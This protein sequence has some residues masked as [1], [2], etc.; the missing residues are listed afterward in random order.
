MKA[1]PPHI[2][3]ERLRQLLQQ[4][5]SFRITN[6]ADWPPEAQKFLKMCA[7]YERFP[8][9][10]RA[11]AMQCIY[12]PVIVHHTQGQVW[13]YAVKHADEGETNILRALLLSPEVEMT[14]DGRALLNDFVSRYRIERTDNKHAL[15]NKIV[16]RYRIEGCVDGQWDMRARARLALSVWKKG[17]GRPATPIYARSDRDAQIYC[18]LHE[19]RTLRKIF[20]RA[21]VSLKQVAEKHKLS[22]STLQNAMNGRRGSE[23]RKADRRRKSNAPALGAGARS[24]AEF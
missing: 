19:L 16:S 21:R 12:L 1:P 8:E 9:D 2:D 13:Y 4:L 17:K 15:F 11:L 5:A 10:I 24:K 14:D 7:T 22:E 3:L 6:W 23:K 18:A 20:G